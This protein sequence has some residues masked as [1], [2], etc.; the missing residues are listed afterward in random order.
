MPKDHLRRAV[1]TRDG[2]L[3]L[4]LDNETGIILPQT[5]RFQHVAAS[6]P[7]DATMVEA[8]DGRMVVVGARGVEPLSAFLQRREPAKEFPKD[9][10]YPSIIDR[11]GALW[12]V[13]STAG[14][15]RIRQPFGPA[16][17]MA[18]TTETVTSRGGLL[19]DQVTAIVEDREGSVWVATQIGLVR[20]SPGNVVAQP[21]PPSGSLSQARSGADVRII[22]AS[23][24]GD[25][26]LA[27]YREL[28]RAGP[29]QALQPQRPL[30]GDIQ[31]LWPDAAGGGVW[32]GTG[33]GRI[34]HIVPG[35]PVQVMQAD[36][37]GGR[38]TTGCVVDRQGRI[39]LSQS[40]AGLYRFAAGR[41]ERITVLSDPNIWPRTMAVDPQGRVILYYGTRSLVRLDGDRVTTLWD[42]E[43]N[44]IGL[45]E[46]IY[47]VGKYIYLGGETGL[48][49]YDGT[50]I[51]VLP[52]ATYPYLAHLSGM[53][54]TAR[55]ETWLIGAGGV[56]RLSSADL[57]AAFAHPGAPLKARAFDQQDGLRGVSQDC[58]CS[59]DMAEAADG[60][61]WFVTTSGAAWIDPGHLQRNT[62]PPPVV[63]RGIEADGVAYPIVPGLRL[64]KGTRTC[65]STI[66]ALSLTA[67]QRVRFRYRLSGRGQAVGG[68]RR[69]ARGLLHQSSVRKVPL[70]GDRREQRWRLERDRRDA[71]FRDSADLPCSRSCS[72]HFASPRAAGVIW[73]LYSLRLQQVAGRLRMR[74]RERIA[75]RE[76]IARELHDTFLQ[77]TQGLVL[78]FQTAAD[79]I[80]PNSP[81][82]QMMEQAL[83]RADEVLAE[84]RD[85][86][87]K[88]R[89]AEIEVALP[90][91][92]EAAARRVLADSAIGVRVV[93]EGA[94]RQIPPSSAKSLRGSRTSSCSTPFGTPRRAGSIS[95]SSMAAR[96][97]RCD[98]STTASAWIRPSCSAARARGTSAW[99]ECASGPNGSR[100]RSRSPAGR[101]PASRRR[102]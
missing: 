17:S 50:G 89:S 45:I 76:R 96:T 5:H 29:G 85:R 78:R 11:D 90:Q 30:G 49:R 75:E 69:P 41:W 39:W 59:N 37:P 10:P 68:S 36:T 19:P 88:L 93:V 32:A 16:G 82:R 72:S 67:P 99:W 79:H 64:P 95:R 60:R 3:W 55:G 4:S 13:V 31:C 43:S 35:R 14:I 27:E 24:T 101:A 46:L 28:L 7:R 44:T 57:D 81:A 56:V 6:I 63:I 52:A 20:F 18:A 40:D 102:S 83:D 84:G 61:I 92:L 74:M 15:Q 26:Y 21:G 94:S 100:R 12:R 70:P 33:L 42:K 97:W 54:Q 1:V 47:P 38:W 51:A 2:K 23:S 73:V 98:W 65:R 71:R 9:E 62:L 87:V 8:P 22:K 48:A 66:P 25:I 77:S 80:A 86:V 34:E 58:G 91:A 53:V